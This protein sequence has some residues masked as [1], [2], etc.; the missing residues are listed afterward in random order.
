MAIDP[1]TIQW[2]APPQTV[3]KPVT[4]SV[5]EPLGGGVIIPAAPD[6]PNLPSP[7]RE[8]ERWRVMTP[9]EIK[10][11]GLQEGQRYQIN[12]AGKIEIITSKELGDSES[13]AVGFY[14]RMRSSDVQ[15]NRLGLDPQGF[16]TLIAQR[17]SPNFSRQ[18]LSDERRAQLDAM[19]NFIA[20]SL[21][22]ES[23]AAIGP[24]EFEKQA[25]IFFPQPGAGQNEIETKR[26]QRELAILGFKAVAGEQGARKADENLRGLGF[27]D[28]NGLPIVQSGAGAD[29]TAAGGAPKSVG[30]GAFMSEQDLALQAELQSAFD[31]G[32]S[33]EELNAINARYGR[34]PLQGIEQ[35]IQ[36]RDAGTKG[37]KANVEPTGFNEAPS[38]LQ[39]TAS[40][41]AVGA[42][43]ALTAGNLDELAPILGLDPQRVEAAKA[44]LRENAPVSSFVGEMTGGALASIPAVR[45]AGAAL[46]GSRLAASAP[47][48]GEMLYGGAYGAGEAPEGQKL[49]GAAIGAGG[50]AVG[51]MLANRFLPGGSGTFLGREAPQPTQSFGGP[52]ASPETVIEAGRQFNVPVMTSD[53]APPQTFM[54]KVSQQ[55]GDFAPFGT[56]GSRRGQQEARQQAVETILAD[57]GVTIDQNFAKEVVSSLT[58]KR[59]LDI[60]N[61]SNLKNEVID[62]LDAAGDV[63]APKALDAIDKLIGSLKGE[64]MSRQLGK[65]ISDLEDTKRSLTGPGGLRKI[66]NNRATIFGLKGDEALSNVKGKAEKAFSAVY[67]ALN[68]DMGDF[69]KANG[70]PKDFVKWKVANKK[71]A[72]MI[73]ELEQQGLKR[74][75]DK[76]DF[77][78]DVVRKM[79]NSKNPQ[80]ARL[81]FTNLGKK[82]RENTRLLLLQDAAQRAF[83]SQTKEINPQEFAKAV[84]GNENAFRMF[85][86]GEE[87]KKVKGLTALL[88][89]TRRAQEAQFAPRTGERLVPFL[90][91]GSF[92][93][94]ATL[95][96]LDFAGGVGLA[97]GFGAARSLYESAPV[98]N[99]LVKIGQTSG[100]AQG[101]L[102]NKLN[103]TLAAS[104]GA[105]TAEKVAGPEPMT[106][107]APAQ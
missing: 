41:Y 77:D 43:N 5:N 59:E 28:E 88:T 11:E 49:T 44:Y 87:A 81:L 86:G 75:L 92:G 22:L 12:E 30:S 74:V 104:A 67:N 39:E 6:K 27:V 58:Q 78:P 76:G 1:K 51:G 68:D 50:A 19:E 66:E 100:T 83:N 3:G 25:R 13:K 52:Q 34:P 80:E 32:V 101:Q 47:L 56:A 15:L 45:G 38:A 10:R 53:V 79:L 103:Q 60:K 73:G 42:A 23:G 36:A 97:S 107:G 37:I 105:V 31:R 62:R 16:A 89:A 48:A 29:G 84:T 99:L 55:V 57:A 33:A 54:G 72:T 94:L 65:L 17:I 26:Q 64:D 85:F 91:A 9:D 82:G 24:S 46:A 102:I 98:R 70:D 20:A 14:Q 21:R 61:F 35:A 93:G 2:D 18:A 95:L 4:G 71:L 63:P 7:T 96:G 8:T 90:S 69:I 106:F 40:G